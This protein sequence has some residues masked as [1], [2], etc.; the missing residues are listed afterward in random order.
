[1]MALLSSP[2]QEAAPNQ[3]YYKTQLTD[4]SKPDAK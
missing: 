2:F 4:V 3:T 1:M